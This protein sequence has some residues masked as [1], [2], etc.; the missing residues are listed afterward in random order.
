MEDYVHS[1]GLKIAGIIAVK[2]AAMALGAACIVSI[3]RISAG[4]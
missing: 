2:F 1:Q 4:S 3:L